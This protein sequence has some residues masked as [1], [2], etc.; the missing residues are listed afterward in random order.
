[1]RHTPEKAAAVADNMVKAAKAAERLAR[2]GITVE[3]VVATH[4]DVRITV[5]PGRA[6]AALKGQWS[7]MRSEGGK[8]LHHMVA[9]FHD[10]L[11]EW[12]T[13][14]CPRPRPQPGDA[15]YWAHDR[16]IELNQTAEV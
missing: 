11:V 15:P 8:K 6:C 14:Y 2:M 13:E 1:M 4:R 16:K 5:R 12:D 10:C 3:T 7:R 9:V